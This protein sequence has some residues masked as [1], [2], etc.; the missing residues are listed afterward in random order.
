MQQ[1]SGFNTLQRLGHFRF[2]AIKFHYNGQWK[3][4][5]LYKEATDVKWH[6]QSWLICGGINQNRCQNK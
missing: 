2:N 4:Q 6:H 5:K 3:N 1:S